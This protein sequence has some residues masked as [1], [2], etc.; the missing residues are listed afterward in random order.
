MNI[1]GVRKEVLSAEAYVAGKSMEDV[2]KEYDLDHVIKLGSNENPYTPFPRT[3]EAMQ[4]ELAQMNIYPEA[5]FLELRER[6]GDMYGVGPDNIGLAHG[7]GGVIE[8][9]GK[10]FVEDGDEVIIPVESYRLYK[11]VCIV[12]GAKIVPV[13]VNEDYTIS[14]ERIIEK[15]TEKTKLIWICNPN[16]PTSTIIPKEGLDKL[17]EVLPETAWV[18]LDEAYAEFADVEDLPGL[19]YIKNEK[20]VI[21]VRTFSKYYGIAGARIGYCI[22]KKD[23]IQGYDTV[24]EPFNSSRIGLT[25]AIM[26]ITEDKPNCDAALGKL[27]ASRTRT[28]VALKDMGLEVVDSKTNFIFFKTPYNA[29][30]IG[31]EMLK[32]GTI[33]R[34]CGGWSFPEHIRVTVGTDEEMNKFLADLKEVL[35]EKAAK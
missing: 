33:I 5:T 19:E 26:S 14:V 11:E 6:L 16:N 20:N 32:K 24:S 22:A 3:I 15:V 28:I 25:A 10:M 13:Y 17:L 18:I 4:G 30:E 34:P 23:V 2:K 31:I 21:K 9:I 8:T 7:A 35:A 12:M 27:I 29:G 1:K